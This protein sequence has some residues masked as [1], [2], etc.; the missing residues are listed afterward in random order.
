MDVTLRIV[1][2]VSPTLDALLRALVPALNGAA[3]GLV[4]GAAADS[5][6]AAVPTAAAGL[7]RQNAPAAAVPDQDGQ[8]SGAGCVAPV[9][10]PGPA[11]AA[12]AGAPEGTPRPPPPASALPRGV[13]RTP[14]RAA[15][16]KELYPAG[17]PMHQIRDRLNE[18]PG[19]VIPPSYKIAAW[20]HDLYVARPIDWD[21]KQAASEGRQALRRARLALLPVAPYTPPA[22]Q[23]APEPADGESP[24]MARAREMLR[25]GLHPNDIRAAVRLSAVE[26]EQL[27]RAHRDAA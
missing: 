20:A 9:Q 11:S 5:S 8:P 16:L 6:L 12:A 1:L 14:E 24:Q 15:L 25:M 27:Q 17:V 22:V 10:V 2:E 3:L 18:L 23:P 4:P 7:T 21:F 19:E 13:F 26:L